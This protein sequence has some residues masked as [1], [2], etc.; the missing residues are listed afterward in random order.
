MT[1]NIDRYSFVGILA[2]KIVKT[3]Y[4]VIL[5][6]QRIG[7]LTLAQN[8]VTFAPAHGIKAYTRLA[9]NQACIDTLLNLVIKAASDARR[10]KSDGYAKDGQ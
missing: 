9:P 3:P 10:A 2:D 5:N 8:K 7:E 6:G 4:A 1:F